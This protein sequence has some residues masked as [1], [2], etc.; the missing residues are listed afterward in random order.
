MEQHAS[1][2]KA[3]DKIDEFLAGEL[4]EEESKMD[5]LDHARDPEKN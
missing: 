3:L 1:I 4:E 2:V 5:G